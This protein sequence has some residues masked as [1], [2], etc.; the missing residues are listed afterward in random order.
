MTKQLQI[1]LGTFAFIVGASTIGF[2]VDTHSGLATTN[3]IA[4]TL[5]GFV[6]VIA[7][8]FR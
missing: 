8:S 1:G 7:G 3:G 4:V 6:A 5:V 2:G